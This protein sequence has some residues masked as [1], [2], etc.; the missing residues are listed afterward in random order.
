MIHK[1]KI[2]PGRLKSCLPDLQAVR[3]RADYKRELLSQ[4]VALRQLKKT[5]EFVRAVE[6]DAAS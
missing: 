2:F 4:K 3:N 6:K 5:E 1:K